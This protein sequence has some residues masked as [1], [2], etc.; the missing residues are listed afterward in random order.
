MF[1]V[2]LVDAL[3]V[4]QPAEDA[5]ALGLVDPLWVAAAGQRA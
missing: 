1:D 3:L 2:E 5:G 4:D